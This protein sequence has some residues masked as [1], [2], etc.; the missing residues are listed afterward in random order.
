MRTARSL[1]YEGGVPVQGRVS[2]QGVSVEGVSV[3]GVTVEGV[4]V[5]GGL[6]QGDPPPWTD[7]HL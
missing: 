2:V 3:E 1:P 5:H 7:R 6:C 4:S